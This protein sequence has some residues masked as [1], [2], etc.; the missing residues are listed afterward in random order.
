MGVEKWLWQGVSTFILIAV[1]VFLKTTIWPYLK[2]QFDLARSDR[3][4]DQKE[5]L[6]ALKD[7]NELFASTITRELASLG[8]IIEEHHESDQKRTGRKPKK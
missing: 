4:E 2:T 6:K 5:F 3:R 1:G 7:Q 8:E